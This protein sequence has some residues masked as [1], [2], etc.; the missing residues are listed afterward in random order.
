MTKKNVY[1]C[2]YIYYGIESFKWPRLMRCYW[3]NIVL[4]LWVCLHTRALNCIRILFYSNVNT[5]QHY[6]NVLVCICAY[7]CVHVPRLLCYYSNGV[8]WYFLIDFWMNAFNSV[9]KQ[10]NCNLM[11]LKLFE[12]FVFFRWKVWQKFSFFIHSNVFWLTFNDLI[13]FLAAFQ[14]NFIHNICVTHI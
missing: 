10:F 6:V 7:V 9:M 14:Y 5:P 11:H 1:V 12:H 2:I 4:L 3:N 8:A 13:W